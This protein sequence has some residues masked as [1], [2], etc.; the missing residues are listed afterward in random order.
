MERRLAARGIAFGADVGQTELRERNSGEVQGRRA[1]RF[2]LAVDVV[3][4]GA[5]AGGDASAR[6]RQHLVAV[7]EVERV[8]R[9][10]L[11][12]RR[13]RVSGGGE[14]AL[15]GRHQH[16]VAFGRRLEVQ[17]VVAQRALA[18]LGRERGPVRRD[19]AERAR[20]HAVAAADALVGVVHDRTFGRLLERRHRARRRARRFVAVHALLLD[21]DGV[22]AGRR[23]GIVD[24]VVRQQHVRL[25]RQPRRVRQAEP[26]LGEL[27]PFAFEAVPLVADDLTG[28]AADAFLGVDEFGV[29][30]RCSGARVARVA[31]TLGPLARTTLTRQA[32]VSWVPAPGS[33]ASIVSS[34]T[35]A[36]VDKPLKPQL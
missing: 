17:T 30:H 32:F 13:H 29:A 5:V 18:D 26:L 23:V 8:G 21:E 31:V 10:G 14:L 4:V 12:A 24:L 16:A 20:E 35:L 25:R 2:L 33:T 15:L 27:R 6:F 34:L 36:P 9:T 22:E 19:R 7:A 11:H 28:L 1:A 3:D